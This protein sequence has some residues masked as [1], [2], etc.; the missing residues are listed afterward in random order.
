MFLTG[1]LATDARQN[2]LGHG[3][4]AG[5]NAGSLSAPAEAVPAAARQAGAG[6]DSSLQRPAEPG[7]GHAA[8]ARH[9]QQ[10]REA[11]VPQLAWVGEQQDGPP[12]GLGLP[13]SSLRR[14]YTGIAKAC[15]YCFCHEMCMFK[16]NFSTI[17]GVGMLCAFL[18]IGSFLDY[19]DLDQ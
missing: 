5:A 16:V 17:L 19:C 12:A 10:D 8:D 14:Y 6:A 13:Q 3:E 4:A 1:C 9:Q 15:F 2:Q 18:A 7:A 11:G